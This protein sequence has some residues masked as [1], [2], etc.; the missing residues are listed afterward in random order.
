M[1][2]MESKK[3]F[4]VKGGKKSRKTGQG[5]GGVGEW[6]PE[7]VCSCWP[8]NF[9]SINMTKFQLLKKGAFDDVLT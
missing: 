7:C 4:V 8:S 1:T 6:G 3:I 2:L 5:G 9:N